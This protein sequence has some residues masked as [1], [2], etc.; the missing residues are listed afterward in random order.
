[1]IDVHSHLASKAYAD[2]DVIIARACSAGVRK[3]VMSITRSKGV[4][5]CE[6]DRRTPSAIGSPHNWFR[7]MLLRSGT[8]RRI[9]IACIFCS[10]CWD[11][12]GRARS[13]Y[14]RDDEQRSLQERRF[15]LAISIAKERRLPVV[16][17]SRSAGKNALA[18]LHSE[19]QTEF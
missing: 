15:R 11:R 6:G 19:G 9:C 16:V 8:L 7:S 5:H 14:I 1:M 18:L 2:I 17:H 10:G 13:F 4:S 12:R 3:I